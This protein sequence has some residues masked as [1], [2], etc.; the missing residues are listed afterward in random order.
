MLVCFRKISENGA[1]HDFRRQALGILDFFRGKKA[2]PA[3]NTET[4][5]GQAPATP[6][7][8]TATGAETEVVTAEETPAAE[9][10]GTAA[11]VTAES[12]TEEPAAET[13]EVPDESGEADKQP[14]G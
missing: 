14:V 2:K 3:E 6:A 11:E 7:A 9:D 1:S 12:G 13:A 5:A 8:E 10:T 4:V